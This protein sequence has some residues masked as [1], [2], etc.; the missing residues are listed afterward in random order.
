MTIDLQQFCALT[1]IHGFFEQPFNIG[2]YTFATNRH[3]MVR[4]PKLEQYEIHINGIMVESIQEMIKQAEKAKD[5]IPLVDWEKPELKECIDCAG[6]GRVDKCKKCNGAGELNQA[7]A[8]PCEDCDTSGVVPGTEKDCHYCN[9]KGKR[10]GFFK[11]CLIGNEIYACAEYIALI[12]S[13]PNP[14]VDISGKPED[15]IPFKFTGGI[16]LLMPMSKD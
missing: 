16:G 6:T 7:Y 14:F 8:E 13:L 11:P 3:L 4:V 15:V 9:G 2:E 12:E 1:D 5:F 10:Y